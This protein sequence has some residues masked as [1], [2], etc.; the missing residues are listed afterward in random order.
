MITFKNGNGF[1]RLQQNE[2]NDF[3]AKNSISLPKDYKVFLL[4][5]NGGSPSPNRNQNPETVVTYVLGM[6]NGE[7]YT[8]LYK[9]ID[10]FKHRLPLSTFP[11]ATDSFGN[12]FIMSLHSDGYGNIYFWDHEGEAVHQDGHYVD[13]CYFVA[14]SFT[15][16]VENLK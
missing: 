4:E 14:Y 3:E 8:S 12:L 15:E 2:L 11:I 6:H 7:Y 9:H 13:N 1:G 16:F 5:F 10:M